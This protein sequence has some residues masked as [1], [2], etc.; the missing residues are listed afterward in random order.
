VRPL[1]LR[2]VLALLAFVHLFP[3]KKH[4]AAF[5]AAPSLDEA[6]KGFGAIAAIAI[7]LLPIRVHARV[8]GALWRDRRMV[9]S[10]AGWTLVCVHL[11]PALDHLPALM[12]TASFGD[13]WRGVGSALACAWFAAP[14]PLQ[15]RVLGGVR[16]DVRALP[17]F[18]FAALGVVF[19]VAVGVRAVQGAQPP[20]T[21][22]VGA[23]AVAI[24]GETADAPWTSAARIVIGSRPYSEARFV[25]DGDALAMMLYAADE[26]IRTTSARHDDPLWIADAFE[27]VFR[28]DGEERTISVSPAGV[29]SDA[30]RA[31]GRLDPSWESGAR[32]AVDTD[33]TL[34][35]ST[36]ADEEWVVELAVPLASLGLSGRAGEH[37]DVTL[38]RC[39]RP[40]G[41]QRTCATSPTRLVFE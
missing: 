8:L 33:G 15:A 14:V 9:L 40:K 24:D 19:G 5:V 21:L 12:H 23:G 10:L 16:A 25:H 18:A 7:Y 17:R 31:H 32:A 36:D 35:D 13:A 34:N 22:H 38:K 37:V 29:I 2:A 1:V 20:S 3:A 30:R 39:D 26:D 6:W 28:V 41:A 11:V 4:L 27:R